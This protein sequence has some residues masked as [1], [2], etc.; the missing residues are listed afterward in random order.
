MLA[1]SLT[2]NRGILGVDERGSCYARALLGERDGRYNMDLSRAWEAEQVECCWSKWPFARLNTVIRVELR[3][4]LLITEAF[5]RP[6]RKEAIRSVT[7]L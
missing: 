7:W 2:T 5:R 3:V 1:E 6:V 4:L